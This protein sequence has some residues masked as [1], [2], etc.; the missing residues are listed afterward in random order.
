MVNLAYN[1][2][3]T[4]VF[5]TA[6][7][8]VVEVL[9]QHCCFKIELF[10]CLHNLSTNRFSSVQL[11]SCVQLFVTPWIT[12]C[13]ASLSITNSWNLLKFM[14]IESV[15]PPSHLILLPPPPPAPNPSQHQGL[16]QWVNSSHEVA[17]VLEFQLQHRSLQWT[18]RSNLL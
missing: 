18:P 16:L 9:K 8:L 3:L 2:T 1:F 6:E 17:K 5:Y 12:A 4:H 14:P 11:L 15:M 7:L 10:K 13:Q